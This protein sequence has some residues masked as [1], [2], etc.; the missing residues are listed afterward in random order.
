MIKKSTNPGPSRNIILIL[1]TVLIFSLM[2]TACGSGKSSAPVTAAAQYNSSK[3]GYDMAPGAPAPYPG[4]AEIT[5]AEEAGFGTNDGSSEQK[6]ES[7]GNIM[8]QRKLIMEGNASI[9]TQHFDDSIA[10]LDQLVNDFGGFAEVRNI[11]GKSKYSNSLRT[12]NFVIRIPAESF[13]LVMKNMGTIGNVL[14]LNSKG[15][16]ITDT[17]YDTQTRI[18][19]LK[20]QEETLLD[21]LSK[22]EKLEDVITLEKRISEVRYE[23]ESLENTIK[24][25]DRLVAFSRISIFIQEV[26]DD[27]KTEPDPKTL[28]ERISGSFKKSL[29]DF[30]DGLE[31]FLV[32]LVGSW[33]SIIF[34]ALA[35][36]I[37]IVLY[38]AKKR[39][40]KRA[41]E[42]A[43]EELAE[44]KE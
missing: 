8:S 38:K 26:D 21:I 1:I 6:T 14:E 25:Y 18:K 13:D 12:A 10:A 11:R 34:V 33:I 30:R 43:A 35:A 28:G 32:W 19:T 23:I 20:V 24:N 22:A 42:K 9:E 2:F 16:D 39:K 27:T 17:Y 15:T 40:S 4:K 5:F 36:V 31:D 41:A 44:K 29:K 37:L 3:A 7:Q